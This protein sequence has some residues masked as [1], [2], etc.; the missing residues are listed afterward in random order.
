MRD[1]KSMT[2]ATPFQ[3]AVFNGYHQGLTNLEIALD[4]GS[5]VGSVKVTA[6]NLGLI[7]TTKRR[8]L[9]V[10][11]GQVTKIALAGPA[12][13]VPDGYRHALVNEANGMEQAA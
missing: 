4:T 10:Q 7:K 11:S 1:R 5:T 6:S 2:P 13:S 9:Q 12:W 8:N 3:Q